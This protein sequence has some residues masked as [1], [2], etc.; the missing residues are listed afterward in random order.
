MASTILDDAFIRAYHTRPRIGDWMVTYTGRQF[1]PVDPRPYEV[2]IRDIAHAL[3]HTCRF[4]GH[5]RTFYSVA[6]HSVLCYEQVT[7]LHLQLPTLM[8]D[9]AEAYMPDIARPLKRQWKHVAAPVE[10]NILMAIWSA[11]SIPLWT[12]PHL[13]QEIKDIDNRMLM[14]EKRDIMTPHPFPWHPDDVAPQPY[15]EKIEPWSPERA[16]HEFLERYCSIMQSRR[17]FTEAVPLGLKP[18]AGIINMKKYVCNDCGREVE[19]TGE[20]WKHKGATQ[21]R[22][23]IVP[24]P[25]D[26]PES[27]TGSAD[28]PRVE[29]DTPFPE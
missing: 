3:A 6:Q 19:Y 18:T 28:S 13:H 25:V 23:I 27:I 5:C 17:H 1:W 8:H 11:F 10:E 15:P 7:E 29:G 20:Y 16:K 9:A 21:Y 14:T 12:L 22:H 24:V 2:D 26:N 4:A